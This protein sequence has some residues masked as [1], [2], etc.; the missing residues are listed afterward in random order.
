VVVDHLTRA[1]AQRAEV[2]VRCFDN[3]S[4]SEAGLRV[5]GY[6]PW[7][8]LAHGPE[9]RYTAVLEALSVDLAMARDPVTADR[10]H[11]HTWYVALAGLLIGVLARIP[12]VVTLH[13]MEPLRPWKEAQL[14]NGYFASSWAER[15]AVER[16]QRVIAVSDQMRADALH[17]FRID[18]E[19]VV[20]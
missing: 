7:E 18:P 1:L 6:R 19:R 20:V 15:A 13:S 4:R 2:E 11:A 3:A 10:L 17:H 12:L 14:G 16:A 9:A 5:Q 8:Q